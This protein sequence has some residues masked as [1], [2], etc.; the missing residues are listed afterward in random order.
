V[1]PRRH[2]HW[3]NDPGDEAPRD[4]ATGA[5]GLA[6]PRYLQ[7]LQEP[8][9]INC[10]VRNFDWSI[11]GK[12]GVIM[13]DPPWHIRQ[14]RTRLNT[15]SALRA[16]VCSSRSANSLVEQRCEVEGKQR[17]RAPDVEIQEQRCAQIHACGC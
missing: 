6:V 5:G 15:G 2:V 3:E 8:Q 16:C 17:A 4:L 7:A 12:F 9:W 14:V 1:L 13:T 10:D 11:L